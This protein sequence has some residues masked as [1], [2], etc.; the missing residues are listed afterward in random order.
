[1]IIQKLQIYTT[2]SVQEFFAEEINIV[3]HFPNNVE[4]QNINHSNRIDV[5]QTLQTGKL[6]IKL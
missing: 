1:M 2:F 5:P 3:Y 4:P 6:K